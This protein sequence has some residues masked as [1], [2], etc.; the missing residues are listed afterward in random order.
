MYLT[1]QANAQS[2]TG[3]TTKDFAPQSGQG[4]GSGG[5]FGYFAPGGKQD[6]EMAKLLKEEASAER[7][8]NSLLVR[9]RGTED[10]AEKTKLKT[11]LNAALVKQFD[12]QQKRREVELVRLEAKLKKVRELMKKR[13]EERKTII[14]K[15]L[16]QLVREAEGLGW[17]PPPGPQTQRFGGMGGFGRNFG[18]DSVLGPSTT[19]P[20]VK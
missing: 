10:E 15:R 13:G 4:Y 12:A 1:W 18:G 19:A 17:A 7:E 16:D 6:E 9:Y 11:S 8:V 14:D 2:P 20:R 3:Q 5:T